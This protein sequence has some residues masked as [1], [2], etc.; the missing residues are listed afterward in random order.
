MQIG[1]DFAA[2]KNQAFRAKIWYL[3]A[4]KLLDRPEVGDAL[5]DLKVRSPLSIAGGRL[6]VCSDAV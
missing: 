6:T 1:S 3:A 2:G 4:I 5:T